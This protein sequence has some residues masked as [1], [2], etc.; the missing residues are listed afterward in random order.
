MHAREEHVREK[1]E[2]ARA[3]TSVPDGHTHGRT[4][5]HTDERTDGH[6]KINMSPPG[7]GRHNNTPWVTGLMLPFTLFRYSEMKMLFVS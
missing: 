6:D 3:L 7:E 2:A 5:G 4:D 1:I